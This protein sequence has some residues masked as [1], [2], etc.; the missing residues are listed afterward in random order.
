MEEKEFRKAQS[1]LKAFTVLANQ[2]NV[3][4]KTFELINSRLP[5][6]VFLNSISQ[7]QKDIG[8]SGFSPSEKSI[9]QLMVNL[10]SD[11]KVSQVDLESIEVDKEAEGLISF[12]LKII[13][14]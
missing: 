10:E 14:N 9:F 6:D 2:E 7:K 13:L 8:V 3:P 4:S 1:K 12:G 11:E 5:N